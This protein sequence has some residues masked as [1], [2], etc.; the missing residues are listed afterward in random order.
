MSGLPDIGIFNTQ[1]GYSRLEWSRLEACLERHVPVP[2][3]ET[4]ARARSSG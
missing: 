1:V 4:R 2:S 3:F